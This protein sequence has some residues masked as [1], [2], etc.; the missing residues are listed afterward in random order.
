[1]ISDTYPT[2]NARTEVSSANSKEKRALTHY[3]SA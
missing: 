2:R 1:M 3:K